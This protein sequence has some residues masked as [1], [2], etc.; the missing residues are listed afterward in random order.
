[1][2]GREE[3]KKREGGGVGVATFSLGWCLHPG[4]NGALLSQVEIPLVT[5]SFV[6]GGVSTQD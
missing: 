2:C 4:L 3:D 1:M 5:N 6:S